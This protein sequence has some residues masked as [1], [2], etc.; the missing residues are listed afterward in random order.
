MNTWK[1]S[2]NWIEYSF[3]NLNVI[4]LKL[5]IWFLSHTDHIQVLTA[6]Y[7]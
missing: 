5:K 2:N 6:A 7:S 4:Q 1:F 3:L